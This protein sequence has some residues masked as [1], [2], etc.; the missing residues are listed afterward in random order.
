PFKIISIAMKSSRGPKH[1]QFHFLEINGCSN[2]CNLKDSVNSRVSGDVSPRIEM[3]ILILHKDLSGL[4]EK[5][6]LSNSR[7]R[8]KNI[9]SEPSVFCNKSSC[10]SNLT[11]LLMRDFPVRRSYS[12]I[13]CFFVHKQKKIRVF[14]QSAFI[15]SEKACAIQQKGMH[16]VTP[17][18]DSVTITFVN[19][20]VHNMVDVITTG[21]IEVNVK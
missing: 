3:I 9:I 4:C 11:P 2:I 13:I 18:K 10:T 5:V 14:F 19:G 15:E 12:T 7:A 20:R 21:K 8:H 17:A 6:N 1:M 16:M